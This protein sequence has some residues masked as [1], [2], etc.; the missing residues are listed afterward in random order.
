[1][2]IDGHSM[3]KKLLLE[4]AGYQSIF[5]AVAEMTVFPH[6]ATVSQTKNKNVFRIIR[7]SHKRGTYN[8]EET[9]MYDDNN[10]PSRVFEWAIEGGLDWKDVQF[11]HIYSGSQN[12]ELYTSLANICVTPA[13]L[14]KLTDTDPEVVELL[15]YR[16]FDL[17]GFLPSGLVAP[18]K[19]AYYDLLK[20][21]AFPDLVHNLE[22]LYRR[23]MKSA[24]KNRAT[25][26]AKKIGWIFSG[27]KADS[28]I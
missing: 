1:M 21:H 24:P 15:K 6:P 13:F 3:L 27:F 7:D 10:G 14:A 19:P 16:A 17:Y 26:S 4:K 8:D 11:N 22:D 12:V 9:A 18:K 28:S 20:W 23:R 5:H 25:I 2:K